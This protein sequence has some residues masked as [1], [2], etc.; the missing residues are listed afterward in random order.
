MIYPINHLD[1]TPLST[2]LEKDLLEQVHDLETKSIDIT[3][4]SIEQMAKINSDTKTLNSINKL[5]SLY[6]FK[7]LPKHL[8]KHISND[9]ESRVRTELKVK[10]PPTVDFEIQAVTADFFP[11][12]SFIHNDGNRPGARRVSWYYLLSDSTAVTRFYTS[13]HPA[14]YGLVWNP[15]EVTEIMSKTM[16]THNWY[17]FNHSHLHGVSGINCPRYALTINFS[18]VYDTY[19]ECMENYKEIIL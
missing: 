6:N 5:K 12:D 11:C 19:E 2:E 13:N 1:L 14:Y 15:V 8:K 7:F 3:V 10:L 4:S 18:K 17:S 9:L 16:K